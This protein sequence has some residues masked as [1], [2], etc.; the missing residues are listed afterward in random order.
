[1]LKYSLTDGGKRRPEY[2]PILF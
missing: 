1:M 2:F